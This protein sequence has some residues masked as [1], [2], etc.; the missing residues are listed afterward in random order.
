[1]R[2][3][4]YKAASRDGAIS[5]GR[6]A[7]ADRT[8]ALDQIEVL[9]LQPLSLTEE[10][11][12]RKPKEA[13]QGHHQEPVRLKP[14]EVLE[15]TEELAELLRGGIHLERS[16]AIIERRK[17]KSRLPLIALELRSRI[18]DGKTLSDALRH[19]SPDF[20]ELYCRLVA[21]GEESGALN[22]ILARQAE[23]LKALQALKS[24]VVF[25]MIYPAF[26]CLSAVGVIVMF[27][28]FLIP[29]LMDLLE[30]TGGSLP[31]GARFIIGLSESFQSTWGFWLGLTVAVILFGSW[32][33]RHR[34]MEWDRL[35]LGSPL[36]GKVMH[37]R[38]QVLFLETMSSLLENG[39]PI[40]NALSLTRNAM[41]S[42]FY[43]KEIDLIRT[44][45][46]DGEGLSD[47]LVHSAC[48]PTI[49]TDL[50]SVGEETG[51]LSGALERASVR[52]EAELKRNVERI[53]AI[54]QPTVVILMA[55]MVGFMAYLM[56]SAIFQ[57]V[58]GL[59]A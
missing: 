40:V 53:S 49:L 33:A 26:L 42:P 15:F 24:G 31:G 17:G 4:L 39:L 21:A 5:N 6:I 37:L 3:F 55:V 45:V 25:A 48:F 41:P 58:S 23:H 7:A 34:S 47:S 52:F 43:R 20:G 14:A 9:G 2:T 44:R 11:P 51:D 38:Q 10:V 35:L 56:I 46:Q 27:V 29:K 22:R 8:S 13:A 28:T 59:G 18:R 36:L 12:G 30:S 57:T 54:I 19:S 50:I 16:L 32:F 1:M